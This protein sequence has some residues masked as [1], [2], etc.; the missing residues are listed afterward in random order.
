MNPA[1]GESLFQYSGTKSKGLDIDV[2][3]LEVVIKPACVIAQFTS[4]FPPNYKEKFSD[5][6]NGAMNWKFNQVPINSHHLF[7]LLQYNET[8][9][10]L[11]RANS[12]LL[13]QQNNANGHHL[14]LSEKQLN[15]INEHQN[16]PIRED[17]DSD[18]ENSSIEE[19]NFD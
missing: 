16:I 15:A 12:N 6:W 9:E 13:Y 7:Q 8:I 1:I 5:I 4:D 18:M 3:D 2:V 10:K 17:N 19:E 11:Q 14:F